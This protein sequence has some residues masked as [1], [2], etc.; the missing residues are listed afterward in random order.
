MYHTTTPPQRAGRRIQP[1]SPKKEGK[2]AEARFLASYPFH[3]DLTDVLYAKWTNLERFQRT[4]GVLRTFALA[5]RARFLE[6]P[7]SLPAWPCAYPEAGNLKLR[8][9]KGGDLVAQERKAGLK[10]ASAEL[11]TNELQDL[12]DSIADLTKGVAQ[13]DGSG[14]SDPASRD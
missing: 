12:V 7:E 14:L 4:R 3:P 10:S 5:L 8:V 9:P 13:E 1:R 2:S 11:R 6:R